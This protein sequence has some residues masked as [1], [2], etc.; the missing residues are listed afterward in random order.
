MILRNSRLPSRVNSKT[1]LVNYKNSAS[2]CLSNN[3][4]DLMTMTAITQISAMKIQANSNVG[5]SQ[6]LLHDT[7]KRRNRKT[8]FEDNRTKIYRNKLIIFKL[9]YEIM[10]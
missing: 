9:I 3:L 2:F 1:T 10:L 6:S 4:V 5:E 7:S 8:N